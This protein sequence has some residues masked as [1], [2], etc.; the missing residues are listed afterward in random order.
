MVG[1]VFLIVV[2]LV[3]SLTAISCSLPSDDRFGA[4]RGGRLLASTVSHSSVHSVV[5]GRG[6]LIGR[7]THLR[8]AMLDELQRRNQRRL[9]RSG[10]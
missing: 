4:T 1:V 10:H 2:G 8:Q 3:I 7:V 9:A 5:D 6:P